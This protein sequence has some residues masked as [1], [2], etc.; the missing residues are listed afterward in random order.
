[1]KQIHSL[2]CTINM[3][4]N[5]FQ[6]NLHILKTC[7]TVVKVYA[8]KIVTLIGL[9]YLLELSIWKLYSI[10]NLQKSA[11][12][13]N[14]RWTRAIH[15]EF[16]GKCPIRELRNEQQKQILLTRI[17]IPDIKKNQ[18]KENSGFKILQ[19]IWGITILVSYDLI[20]VFLKK[21]H[22]FEVD[23]TRIRNNLDASH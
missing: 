22:Y 9:I 6:K 13:Y 14:S 4:T 11:S 10:L 1:M 21:Y 16:Q 12:G 18:W 5:Y 17:N 15:V 19:N 23:N 8:F 2:V 20:K 3:Q 7:L